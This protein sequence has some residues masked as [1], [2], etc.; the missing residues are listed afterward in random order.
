M[1]SLQQFAQQTQRT[2]LV[3]FLRQYLLGGLL[4]CREQISRLFRSISSI[5]EHIPRITDLESREQHLG[6]EFGRSWLYPWII[7]PEL[8]NKSTFNF[9]YSWN[10]FKLGR[11]SSLI[12]TIVAMCMT[13]GKESFDDW[14]IFTWSLGCTNLSPTFPPR[15]CVARFA[16]T[17][18]AFMFDWVPDPV[19][20]TTNGN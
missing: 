8:K 7:Q 19:C 18:L 14:P 2:C 3:L 1:R 4:E 16:I 5:D 17:S 10:Y 9:I 20:Q 13:V 11:R 6:C 15:I 12:S